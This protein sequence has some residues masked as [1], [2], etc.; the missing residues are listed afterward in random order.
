MSKKSNRSINPE[1]SKTFGQ[2][3]KSLLDAD[4][5]TKGILSGDRIL[6]SKAITYIESEHAKHQNIAK[7]VLQ[8]CIPHI[9][10]SF[11]IGVTGSPGVGKST[12]IESIGSEITK[13]NNKLAV[14]AIDPTSQIGHGSIL[15]DKTRMQQ[16]TTNDQVFIRPSPA[17]N[18]L[19]GVAKKTRE[20]IMLCEAAGYDT[21]VIETV[22]VGQ[23][24][25]AVHSMVDCF[26]LLILP[27]AGDDLQ[28]IKRGIVEMADIVIVNKADQDRI[29][30]AKASKRAYKNALHLFPPKE[31]N[32]AVKILTCS[33]LENLGI[34]EAW[35]T[36]LDFQKHI[37]DNNY[38]QHHRS[39]QAKYWLYES[40]EQQLKSDFYTHPDIKEKLTNIEAEVRA[41]KMNPFE[42][43]ETLLKLFKHEI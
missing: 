15:G 29:K 22:G 8:N 9:K 21:V 18:S 43:A 14:L 38:F 12:F 37:T 5:L 24:E 42:G 11:R 34:S 30:L 40:I 39:Q 2:A 41:G 32:W 33:A 27:G 26:M 4:A 13:Q 19:G 3:K 1:A 10:P 35:Q 16:L 6:L 28:G 17:G 20:T 31:S 23:S 25:I 7:Q 36:L